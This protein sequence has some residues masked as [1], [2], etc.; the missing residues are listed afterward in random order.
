MVRR[1]GLLYLRGAY[2]PPQGWD[3]VEA[4]DGCWWTDI[5]GNIVRREVAGA[6]VAG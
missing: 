3:V 5:G 2:L 4:L 1:I 6:V